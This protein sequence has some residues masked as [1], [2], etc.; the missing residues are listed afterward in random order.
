M[1]VP[2]WF[3]NVW[4]APVGLP[5]EGSIQIGKVAL[6]VSASKTVKVYP[7][8]RNA[9]QVKLFETGGFNAASWEDLSREHS[10]TF[11]SDGTKTLYAAFRNPAGIVLGDDESISATV[12]IDSDY[13]SGLPVVLFE[14]ILTILRQDTTLKTYHADWDST[15]A[16]KL[17]VIPGWSA[18]PIQVIGDRNMG[19]MP[20]LEVRLGT[21]SI[22]YP[23]GP[24]LYEVTVS[25][26]IRAWRTVPVDGDDKTRETL[27]HK[28]LWDVMEALNTYPYVQNN[29][30]V[31]RSSPTSLD[32]NVAD[33][34]AYR[35]GQVS[36]TVYCTVSLQDIT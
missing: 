6:G 25:V 30:Y 26:D 18:D 36:H 28:Y 29:V 10:Y 12:L 32:P 20:F 8:C 4:Q 17:H 13:S 27:V 22:T 14:D 11:A 9:S 2:S 31:V 19:R 1:A 3:R 35:V 23:E 21:T 5:I 16:G 34:R 33:G 15:T 24:G 7:V